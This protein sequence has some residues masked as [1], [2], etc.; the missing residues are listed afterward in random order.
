MKLG[1]VILP[2]LLLANCTRVVEVQSEPESD[3]QKKE[4][5]P[6]YP[7]PIYTDI[8]TGSTPVNKPAAVNLTGQYR[9]ECHV[10]DE[11]EGIYLQ[12]TLTILDAGKFLWES[13]YA[14]DDSCAEQ[15]TFTDSGTFSLG[16]AVAGA[17]NRFIFKQSTA[18]QLARVNE[19]NVDGYNAEEIYGYDDWEVGVDKDITSEVPDEMGDWFIQVQVLADSGQIQFNTRTRDMQ[20]AVQTLDPDNLFRKV[21]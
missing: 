2:L 19:D 10:V 1:W 15:V 20:S 3:D 4:S 6:S 17:E 18:K 11:D 5:R 21:E 8:E 9:T 16:D 14:I 13:V 12:Q 7:D